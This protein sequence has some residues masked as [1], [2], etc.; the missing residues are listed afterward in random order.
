VCIAGNNK[1]RIHYSDGFGH[2]GSDDR[3]SIAKFLESHRNNPDVDSRIHAIWYFV[4]SAEEIPDSEQELFKMDFGEIPVLAVLQNEEKL[5]DRFREDNV[6]AGYRAEVMAQKM[7]E[8]AITK[9]KD[10]MTSLPVRKYVQA[11]NSKKSNF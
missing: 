6:D 7:F 3:A 11:R 9:L 2:G 1:V 10:S 8:E 5:R 4:D